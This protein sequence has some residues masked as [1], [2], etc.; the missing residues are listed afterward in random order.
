VPP[1]ALANGFAALGDGPLAGAWAQRCLRSFPRLAAL[2]NDAAVRAIEFL[3][4]PATASF[5]AQALDVLVAKAREEEGYW[6]GDAMGHAIE[7]AAF[8]RRW[9]IVG[10]LEKEIEAG[11]D[12]GGSDLDAAFESL[13]VVAAGRGDLTRARASIERMELGDGSMRDAARRR[14]VGALLRNGSLPDARALAQEVTELDV[15]LDALGEVV[16]NALVAD[17][18]AFAAETVEAVIAASGNLDQPATTAYVLSSIALALVRS[19]RPDDARRL[20]LEAKASMDRT[21]PDARTG[22]DTEP[23]ARALVQ[24]GALDVAE[25][26]IETMMESFRTRARRELVLALRA[27]GHAARAEAIVQRMRDEDSDDYL[28]SPGYRLATIA[29]LGRTAGDMEQARDDVEEAERIYFADRSS[30]SLHQATALLK[31]MEEYAALEDRQDV[32]RVSAQVVAAQMPSAQDIELSL[33][34]AAGLRA[35]G[36][37]AGAKS[38]ASGALE[39]F[40]ADDRSSPYS[41]PRN[42]PELA[43]LAG[44]AALPL[45]DRL[46]RL[47]QAIADPHDRTD[48]LRCLALSFRAAGDAPRALQSLREAMQAARSTSLFVTL[49][50]IAES[51]DILAELDGGDTLLRLALAYEDVMGWW[52]AGEAK[53]APSRKRP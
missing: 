23:V 33:V 13:A 47:F 48:H 37:E 2:A 7:A 31:I 44:S 51:A 38:L 9:D 32:A 53:T 42:L 26:F 14:A 10:D 24:V 6:H 40:E 11:R 15:R 28:D 30:E 3:G 18:Q 34:A 46:H 17:D 50:S 43:R 52:S 41:A 4:T 5:Q 8:A 49:E 20:A 36:D 45:L 25:P 27:D 22:R 21:L 39:R 16:R 19:G 29:E 12:Q 35:R 1:A